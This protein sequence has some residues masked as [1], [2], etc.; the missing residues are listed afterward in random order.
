MREKKSDGQRVTKMMKG[1]WGKMGMQ[2]GLS[3]R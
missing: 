1:E 2:E 3:E